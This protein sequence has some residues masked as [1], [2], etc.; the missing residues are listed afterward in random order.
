MSI[1]IKKLLNTESTIYVTIPDKKSEGEEPQQQFHTETD[2][3]LSF[4]TGSRGFVV[5]KKA[6]KVEKVVKV[7]KVF[8]VM[9]YNDRRSFFFHSSMKNGIILNGTSFTYDTDGFVWFDEP[10]CFVKNEDGLVMV[11]MA[12]NGLYCVNNEALFII[13]GIKMSQALKVV[14]EKEDENSASTSKALRYF[15]CKTED[16]A[17]VHYDGFIETTGN[18]LIFEKNRIV[19]DPSATP[20]ELLYV[21]YNDGTFADVVFSETKTY[22]IYL[23]ESYKGTFNL[24]GGYRCKTVS[25]PRISKPD[26]SRKSIISVDV[27]RYDQTSPTLKFECNW[28]TQMEMSIRCVYMTAYHPNQKLSFDLG[29]YDTSISSPSSNS[30]SNEDDL[31]SLAMSQSQSQSSKVVPITQWHTKL[32]CKFANGISGSIVIYR[33]L[34]KVTEKKNEMVRF[35]NSSILGPF[36]SNKVYM[37]NDTIYTESTTEA[38]ENKNGN[39]IFEN[40]SLTI[41]PKIGMK[42]FGVFSETDNVWHITELRHSIRF[43]EQYTMNVMAHRSEIQMKTIGMYDTADVFKYYEGNTE[44][45]K[46]RYKIKASEDISSGTVIENKLFTAVHSESGKKYNFKIEFIY[47]EFARVSFIDSDDENFSTPLFRR[48]SFSGQPS[49]EPFW[50]YGPFVSKSGKPIFAYGNEVVNGSLD[51]NVF[52]II[53]FNEATSGYINKTNGSLPIITKVLDE[54]MTIKLDSGDEYVR[55]NGC[56]NVKFENSTVI[57][58]KNVGLAFFRAGANLYLLR[59]ASIRGASFERGRSLSAPSSPA[60]ASLPLPLQSSPASPK[61]DETSTSASPPASA[62]PL[63]IQTQK[64]EVPVPVPAPAPVAVS[65]PVV[66]KSNP[67]AGIAQRLVS[68]LVAGNINT[69][70]SKP[71][72]STAT[73]TAPRTTAPIPIAT[74]TQNQH[75]PRV[76]KM[77]PNAKK[78][79]PAISTVSATTLAPVSVPMPATPKVVIASTSIFPQKATRPLPLLKK[80]ISIALYA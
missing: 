75:Q 39:A 66:P 9:R 60:E 46:G 35:D 65:I 36:T 10:E 14:Q 18:M 7:G 59:S 67:N 52:P 25:L 23:P 8:D 51:S 26:D 31:S 40:D 42:Q 34:R 50:T 79:S 69:V 56:S 17:S 33:E 77:I 64:T 20:N 73:A 15:K 22:P 32:N 58:P 28:L 38:G 45:S 49:A 11:E 3:E 43:N 72:T 29:K 47:Q 80:P 70:V 19:F 30:P 61:S 27:L 76:I 13:E 62:S 37:I 55:L 1:I 48:L 44:L 78:S 21:K 2:N 5:F 4:P 63:V 74:P 54:D 53:T 12:N 71:A 57:V 68:K 24:L 6:D 16:I 41:R